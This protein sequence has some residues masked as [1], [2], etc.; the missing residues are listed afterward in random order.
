MVE[1]FESAAIIAGAILLEYP[2]LSIEHIVQM[3]ASGAPAFVRT[4][5]AQK[6]RLTFSHARPESEALAFRH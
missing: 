1:R 4:H 2:Q 6:T 3:L 5:T